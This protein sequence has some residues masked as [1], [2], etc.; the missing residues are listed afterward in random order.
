MILYTKSLL[1]IVAAALGILVTGLADDV[2]TAAELTNVAIAIVTALGVYLVPNLPSG[3][4]A[5]LKFAVALLGAA[6]VA[7]SSFLDGGVSTS[8]WLQV[9]LAGL[10]AIGVYVVPNIPLLDAG[11]LVPGTTVTITSMGQ[12]S[13]KTIAAVIAADESPDLRGV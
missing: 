7:L 5:Y 11:T 6:L 4:A 8:E 12:P 10:T 1:A 9:A 2:L 3:P 13:E